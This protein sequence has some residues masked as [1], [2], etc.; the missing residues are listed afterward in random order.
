VT[1][2]DWALVI[3]IFSAVVSL[4]GFVWNVWSKFIYPKPR[5]RVSFSMVTAFYPGHQRDP[6]PVRALRLSATNF[7]PA[8]VTLLSSLIRFKP[9]WF[10][11]TSHGLLNTFSNFP[12]STDYEA[13]YE[14][15]G[16]GPFA[17]GFP[18]KLGVGESF[19]VYLVPDHETLAKGN[20]ESIGF[21]DS[22]DQIHW[23]PRQDILRTLPSIREACE[24]I[25]K[26]WRSLR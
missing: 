7:G 14:S 19:S 3:S 24:R 8:D 22:F 23:A 1:T 10:S 16:G 15:G 5:V 4:A 20:Y 2:A 17:A 12:S 25:G 6:D 26:D 13:E 9:H 11:D 18:K 21:N